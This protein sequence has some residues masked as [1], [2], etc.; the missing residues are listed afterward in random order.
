MIKRISEILSAFKVFQEHGKGQR[1]G[2]VEQHSH[3]KGALGI[4]QGHLLFR[5]SQKTVM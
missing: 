2:P 4:D 3:C 1:S 5:Q